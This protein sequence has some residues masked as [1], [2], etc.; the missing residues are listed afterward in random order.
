M[1]AALMDPVLSPFTAVREAPVSVIAVVHG[2]ANGLGCALAA[3]CDVTIAADDALFGIPAG[4]RDLCRG[5]PLIR[6]LLKYRDF[7]LFPGDN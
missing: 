7:F 3:V 2:L 4:A 6:N 1:R 5:P